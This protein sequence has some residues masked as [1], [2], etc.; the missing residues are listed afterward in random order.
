MQLRACNRKAQLASHAP[1]DLIMLAVKPKRVQ[2]AVVEA[3]QHLG[4][5]RHR[6]R[7]ISGRKPA[8]SNAVIA[9]LNRHTRLVAERLLPC[10]VQAGQQPAQDGRAQARAQPQHAGRGQLQGARRRPRYTQVRAVGCAASQLSVLTSWRLARCLCSR[11][12]QVTK[13]RHELVCACGHGK[14]ITGQVTATPH[15]ADN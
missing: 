15:H 4:M 12:R 14:G 5:Y 11:H 6:G 2:T 10:A 7:Q 8:A 9:L 1:Y 13:Q 3:R